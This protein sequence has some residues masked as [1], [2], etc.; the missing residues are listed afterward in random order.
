M[1]F[2]H[3]RVQARRSIKAFGI[4]DKNISTETGNAASVFVYT[5]VYSFKE[6][7]IIILDNTNSLHLT[8]QMLSC[9]K[10]L[11]CVATGL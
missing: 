6:N 3:N 4:T 5:I 2:L 11:N 1:E 9:K 10:M 7:E 8:F